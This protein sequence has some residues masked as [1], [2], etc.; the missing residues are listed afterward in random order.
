MILFAL[1]PSATRIGYAL[2]RFDEHGAPIERIERVSGGSIDAGRPKK[3][4]PVDHVA[5]MIDL[6]DRTMTIAANLTDRFGE[7][8]YIGV[9]WP[10][11]A[12]M[13]TNLKA[14]ATYSVA[15]GF[16]MAGITPYAPPGRVIPI[17]ADVWTK[18]GGGT[19]VVK[20]RRNAYLPGYSPVG[21]SGGD[22]GD[23]W[24]FGVYLIQ[25]RALT[26]P[27]PLDPKRKSRSCPALRGSNAAG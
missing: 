27:P 5:R 14:F 18:L 24:R 15:V 23:A 17:R 13:A 21:D 22:I 8:D 4:A 2:L 3:G 9:E 6:R 11:C 12:R 26:N 7:F 16:I 20:S 19:A 25:H 10:N 1:D